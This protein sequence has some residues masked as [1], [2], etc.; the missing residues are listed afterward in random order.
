MKK[1]GFVFSTPPHGQAAGREGLDAILATSNYT[2]NMALFFIGDGV[3]Q[4]LANQIPTDI[5]SRDYISTFKMLPLCDIDEVYICA[6]SL[7]ERGLTDA[8]FVIDVEQ[9]SA[10][11]MHQLMKQC[12][13]LLRF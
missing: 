9:K 4:L 7:T 11:D 10:S 5:L 2:E 13:H 6:S 12:H 1:L 3:F 8:D